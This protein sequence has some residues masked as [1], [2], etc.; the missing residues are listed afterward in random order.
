MRAEASASR[1]QWIDI[2][3][4]V[5]VSLF[6]AAIPLGL[7]DVVFR[8]FD[9]MYGGP[10]AQR[11]WSVAA[12]IG[13]GLIAVLGLVSAWIVAAS[14]DAAL[15]AHRRRSLGVAL[16]LLGGIG[17]ALYLLVDWLFGGRVVPDMFL[18]VVGAVLAVAPMLVAARHLPRIVRALPPAVMLRG[19]RYGQ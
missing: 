14:S 2:V 6:G 13:F 5:P 9:P 12:Q 3:L 1:P 4:L 15:R 18:V 11:W 17:V 10:T 16:G 7:L 8:L 19:C